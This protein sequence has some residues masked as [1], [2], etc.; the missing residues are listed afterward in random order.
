[1]ELRAGLYAGAGRDVK[2]ANL[3]SLQP[4]LSPAVLAC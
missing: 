2:A 1:V 4:S 3:L